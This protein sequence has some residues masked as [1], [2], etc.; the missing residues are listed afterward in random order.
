M[1]IISY[2]ASYLTPE[3][4]MTNFYLPNVNDWHAIG[5]LFL[6]TFYWLT[7]GSLGA[8]GKKICHVKYDCFG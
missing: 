1:V 8:L 3:A 2:P 7:V 4:Q 6:S 5:K